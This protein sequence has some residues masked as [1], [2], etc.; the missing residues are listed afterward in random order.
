MQPLNTWMSQVRKLMNCNKLFNRLGVLWHLIVNFVTK[1]PLYHCIEP[2]SW[3]GLTAGS[4]LPKVIDRVPDDIRCS[5]RGRP[6]PTISWLKDGVEVTATSALYTV[7]H[8]EK[9]IGEHSWNVTSVLSWQGELRTPK[10]QLWQNK[11]GLLQMIDHSYN[12]TCVNV[13]RSKQICEQRS[14]AAGRWK[15]QL[16]V[17]R[18]ANWSTVSYVI[19]CP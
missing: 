14:P 1:Q 17:Y 13:H 18:Q 10:Y 6:K 15:W 4:S 8:L 2:P 19:V 7:K 16:H 3:L 5:V 11:M 12:V 9:A